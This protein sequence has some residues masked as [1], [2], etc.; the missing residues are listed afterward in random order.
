MQTNRRE[1]IFRA[2]S[3]CAA[4]AGIGVIAAELESCAPA[5]GLVVTKN[6]ITIPLASFREQNQYVVK[7][8]LLD[9]DILVIRHPDNTF[10]ALQLRCSHQNYPLKI[11]PTQ[12]VCDNHGSTFDFDGNATREPAFKP[13]TKYNVSVENEKV[14][15]DLKG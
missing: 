5:K 14:I 1:F 6:N 7:S 4:L 11:T 2:C 8:I 3:F 10:L 15:V 9:Y 13:L 12:L